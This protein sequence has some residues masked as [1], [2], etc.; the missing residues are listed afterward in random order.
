MQAVLAIIMENKFLLLWKENENYL[1]AHPDID[2]IHQGPTP[3]I[4]LER[5]Q[6][7]LL[8]LVFNSSN[9]YVK[10][11]EPPLEVRNKWIAKSKEYQKEREK[12]NGKRF[13]N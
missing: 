4:A 2:L 8:C 1:V 12:E 3:E 9:A 5:Y 11:P 10:L 6:K 13:N 7:A